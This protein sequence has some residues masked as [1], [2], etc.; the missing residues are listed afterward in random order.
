MFCIFTTNTTKNTFGYLIVNGILRYLHIYYLEEVMARKNK[1]DEYLDFADWKNEE[2]EDKKI[3]DEDF[4]ANNSKP[5]EIQGL[6]ISKDEEVFDLSSLI[7]GVNAQNENYVNTFKEEEQSNLEEQKRLEEEK[8][9]AEAAEEARKL[10]EKEQAERDARIFAE[11]EAEAKRI[12]E[13]LEKKQNSFMNKMF[14][15]NTNSKKK[16]DKPANVEETKEEEETKQPEVVEPEVEEVS[17]EPVSVEEEKEVE[18]YSPAE[19]GD[20]DSKLVAAGKVDTA[21]KKPNRFSFTKEKPAVEKPE[22]SE[23]PKEEKL[24]R[25]E[26]AAAKKAEAEAKALELKEQ[27]AREKERKQ[28]EAEQAREEKKNKLKS[29]KEEKIKRPVKEESQE[30]PVKE[31]AD[32]SKEKKGLFFGKKPKDNGKTDTASKTETDWEYLA[33]HDE[34]TGLLNQ[35]AYE[36]AKNANRDYP[37]AIIYIDANN[38]KYV[39]DNIGHEAGNK[40]LIAIS[41]LIKNI[42]KDEEGFRTGGDEFVVIME[43]ISPKKVDKILAK[44]REQFHKEMEGFTKGSD[45]KGMVY[46]ASLGFAISD[47]SKS[48]KDTASEAEKAMYAEKAAYKKA[49][50]KYDM[51]RA[52]EPEPPKPK[53]GGALPSR[54]PANVPENYDDMLSKEQRELKSSIR[55]GHVKVSTK[56]TQEI[57][58]E[59]QR[60]S[61]EIVAILIASPTFDQLFII[62]TAATFVNV[63]MESDF[64][65]DYSFLY[66][67]YRNE[68]VYKGADEYFDEVTGIFDAIG[69]GLIT[70]KIQ[71]EKDL[72][73]IKGINIF[74]NIYVDS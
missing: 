72:L 20:T 47:G 41:D 27:K 68:S 73:K 62:Q 66:I 14:K 74:K 3:Q 34:M 70:G 65:I 54:G 46:S 39:N 35:R 64:L 12:A 31:D 52:R 42:F 16:N 23:K 36:Q 59:I 17:N 56:S 61:T 67:I 55:N 25:K 69:K 51:R 43:D 28:Q 18:V 11:K 40:L 58:R 29:Q 50:P 63:T 19:Y 60:R 21:K 22:K 10:Y 8:L 48:Y 30:E 2:Q 26:I 32:N 6:G 37:F 33:N 57:V 71:S 4:A 49:N 13:E 53:K 45:I 44:K 7:A 24:S 9:A 1:W 5:M 38:L 15:S